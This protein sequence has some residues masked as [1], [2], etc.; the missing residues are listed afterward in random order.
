MLL[1]TD[2][3]GLFFLS[4]SVFWAPIVRTLSETS[5]DH[6]LCCTLVQLLHRLSL[7]SFS[8]NQLFHLL[9]SCFCC[10]LNRATWS[11]IICDFRM[12]L[13]EFLHLDVNRFTRQTLPTVNRTRFFMNILCTESFRPQK[14]RHN[15][16]LLFEHTPRPRSPF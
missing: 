14:K 16:T 15:R 8:L 12:S 13:R 10:N 11:G 1:E 9:H 2:P 5:N 7:S 4:P 6:A 3:F